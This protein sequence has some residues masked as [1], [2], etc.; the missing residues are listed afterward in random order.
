[1]KR[2]YLLFLVSVIS[3]SPLLAQFTP[4]GNA[5]QTSTSCYTLT[6]NTAGQVGA[7]WHAQAID[8]TR[9][10]DVFA[11][12]FFG[13][14][15]GGADGIDF[16]FHNNPVAIG[17]GGAGMGYAGITPSVAV[18]FDTWQNGWLNDPPGDHL[19]VV[20]NGVNSHT[21]ANSLAGPVAILPTGGNVETCNFRNIRI[22]WDPVNDSL[23][24]W[25]NCDL[26]L[27]YTGDIINNIFGGNPVV[28]WG[29][30]SSTGAASNLHQVCVNY[31]NNYR[32]ATICY[33]DTLTLNSG[34]GTAN[35]IS[36][37]YAWTPATNISNSTI[38]NPMVF[39][40]TTS[41]YTVDV[42]DGCGITR[43]R[44]WD[45][46][47]GYDT[48]LNVDLGPDTTLCNGQTLD[49]DVYVPGIDYLWQDGL[50]DSART[51]AVA[52]TYW[53]ETSNFCGVRR[54]TIIIGNGVVPDIN[55]G[56]DTTICAGTMITLDATTPEGIYTWQDNS[57]DSSLDVSVAGLYFVEVNNTCGI[58][59]DSIII[60]TTTP[61]TA[62]SLGADTVLCNANNWLIDVTDP[63][64]TSYLWQNGTMMTTFDVQGPGI[65]H[66]TLGNKCGTTADTVLVDYDA[67][68]T[69]D[70]GPDTTLC[71]GTIYFLNA[72]FSPYTTYLWQDNTTGPTKIVT[73]PGTYSVTLNNSCGTANDNLVVT[74]LDP[75]PTPDLGPDTILCGNA[76]IVLNSGLSG[77][78][79]EWQDGSTNPTYT[80]NTDGTYT[81]EVS[82]RCGS[83]QDE[84]IVRYETIPVIDLGN[85]TTL[86][87]GQSIRLDAAYSRSSYRWENGFTGPVRDI[88][89]QGRYE[90]TVTNICGEDRD[91]IN[92]NFLPYPENVDLGGDQTLCDGEV[93]LFDVTQPGFTYQ[94]QNGS[95]EPDY[96][97]RFAGTYWVRVGNVCGTEVDQVTIDYLPTPELELGEDQVLCNGELLR[98]DGTSPTENVSYSWDNGNNSPVRSIDEAGLYRLTVSNSCD[99]VTDSITITLQECNCLVHMPTG[100]TPNDDGNNDEY[101]WAFSCDMQTSMLRIFDRWG[102]VVY[103]SNDPNAGWNGRLQ[104]GTDA[105]EGVYIWV[106][107][108]NFYGITDALIEDQQTGTVTLL[109]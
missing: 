105:P 84:V 22:T 86:C 12:V 36:T 53:V 59:R 19:A 14:A 7:I 80:V 60:S 11:S 104:N 69:V 88:I 82:N 74:Y 76:S 41:T 28:Y 29:F 37:T 107:D 94:W 3:A 57:T 73:N 48:V 51:V 77:Y 5:T 56:N 34:I 102:R 31:F 16:V 93:L 55:L 46:T 15:D 20:S 98:L 64:A 70:L 4:L 23:S 9:P 62:F 49:L 72:A 78:D 103:E 40:D 91:V 47:V 71:T 90:V 81:L 30:V 1:M 2:F 109:R 61:P 87:D 65:Y 67:T 50:T 6:G 100:F 26:R 106:L 85:D 18:E 95:T 32:P 99:A 39:P 33:P 42:T 54:D 66:V 83:A 92:V 38:R 58:D 45:I 35:G 63:L 97:V 108:Y 27:T 10:F 43:T 96:L 89:D 24:V 44:S 75:P 52:D 101:T 13:C 79:F 68:P 8:L 21:G 25:V 17:T